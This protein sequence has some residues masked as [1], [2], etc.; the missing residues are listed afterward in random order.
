MTTG[1]SCYKNGAH[2]LNETPVALDPRVRGDGMRRER[3]LVADVFV[4]RH[5]ISGLNSFRNFRVSSP[6]I[7]NWPSPR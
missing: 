4:L 3:R 7:M 2:R 5:S 1:R 6:E